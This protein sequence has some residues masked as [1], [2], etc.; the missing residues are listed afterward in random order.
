MYL[1]IKDVDAMELTD[2][3][4][5]SITRYYNTLE[6]TGYIPDSQLC[7]LLMMVFIEEMLYG[8]LGSFITEKDYKAIGRAL[9][10]I[11]GTCLIPYPEYL[12]SIDTVTENPLYNEYRVTEDCI[13]R[14]AVGLRVK[15]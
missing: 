15:V 9:N 12:R 7:S 1:I 13:L 11:S 14:D 4:L 6:H 5:D 2:D 10:C 3:V 8:E